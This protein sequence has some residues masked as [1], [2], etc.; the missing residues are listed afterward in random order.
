[1]GLTAV[2]PIRRNF[3]FRDD[4]AITSRQLVS[5]SSVVAYSFVQGPT[6]RRPDDNYSRRNEDAKDH[7]HRSTSRLSAK[8][9]VVTLQRQLQ[10]YNVTDTNSS[11]TIESAKPRCHPRAV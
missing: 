6:G 3:A 11:K 10:S 9:A 2:T 4:S 1:V 7:C 5:R 8:P